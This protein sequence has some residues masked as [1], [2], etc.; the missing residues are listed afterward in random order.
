MSRAVSLLVVCF[1]LLLEI[2][3]VIRIFAFASFCLYVFYN[4]I[5]LS[6]I[7]LS[8]LSASGGFL[9]L[10]LKYLSRLFAITKFN[11]LGFYIK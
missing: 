4:F 5:V 1:S 3:F 10:L 8:N 2:L 11:I 9:Y 7:F 6:I